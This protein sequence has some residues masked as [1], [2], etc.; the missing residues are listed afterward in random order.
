MKFLLVVKQCLRTLF[1]VHACFWSSVVFAQLPALATVNGL[2]VTVADVQ[3]DALRIPADSRKAALSAPESVFQL[4]LNLLT[5]RALAAQAEAAG[6]ANDPAV[7]AAMQIARER[8]LSDLYIARLDAANKPTDQA[9]E[10]LASATYK[11]NPKRFDLPEETR[12][13]H[14]LIKSETPDAKAK[15]EEVLSQLQKGADFAALAKEK[16]QDP[17]S[18]DKGGDLGFF[19]KGRMVPA[20][21]EALA[22]LKSPNELSAVVESPFGFHVIRL[23]ERKSAGI[24]SFA[25][26]KGGLIPELLNKVTSEARSVEIQKIQNAV[27]FN[28]PAMEEFANSNK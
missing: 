4:S 23:T 14:I 18:A 28:R 11:S 17:G 1:L 3:G 10:A 8:V 16:S 22:K 19:P 25:E 24:R 26:V 9:L 6:L 27:V 2:T 21:E 20:F 12:A 5:R 7:Q 13:S 15:A